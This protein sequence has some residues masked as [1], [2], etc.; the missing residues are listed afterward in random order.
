MSISEIFVDVR[1]SFGMSNDT[2]GALKWFFQDGSPLGYLG[3]AHFTRVRPT[4]SPL[5]LSS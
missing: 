5:P 1:S 3:W 4:S 2:L